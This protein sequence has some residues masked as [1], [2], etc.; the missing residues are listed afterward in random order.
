MNICELFKQPYMKIMFIYIENDIIT[1]FFGLLLT[2]INVHG[3][4]NDNSLFALFPFPK[5]FMMEKHS[6][7]YNEKKREK[8]KQQK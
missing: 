5:I 3:H 6:S 7:E 2:D 8:K 4:I 1:P